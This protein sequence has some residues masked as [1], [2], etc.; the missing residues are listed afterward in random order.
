MGEMTVRKKLVIAY[1]SAVIA[2]VVVMRSLSLARVHWAFFWIAAALVA[3]ALFA[4]VTR[5]KCPH[6]HARAFKRRWLVL[7]YAPATCAN[8][9]RE[10]YD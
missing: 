8:C 5:L 7:F 3:T 4:Y 1:I 9:D 6:C 10:F 2:F